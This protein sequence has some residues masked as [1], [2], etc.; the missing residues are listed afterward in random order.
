MLKFSVGSVSPQRD[1]KKKAED[2]EEIKELEESTKSLNKRFTDLELK[3]TELCALN[4]RS[5]ENCV[6]IGRSHEG[7]NSIP[8]ARKCVEK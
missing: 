5:E 4:E 1:V 3:P 8:Y 2:A 6:Q 7:M